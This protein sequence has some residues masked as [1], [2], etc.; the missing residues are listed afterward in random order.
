MATINRLEKRMTRRS[1]RSSH[2]T[3]PYRFKCDQEMVYGVKFY[4]VYHPDGIKARRCCCNPYP[5]EY[6]ELLVTIDTPWNPALENERTAFYKETYK[7][8]V[9]GGKRR[10]QSKLSQNFVTNYFILH[11]F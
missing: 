3:N 4:G 11:C 7:L 8:A 9:Q 5:G 1:K 2:L 10:I 6:F